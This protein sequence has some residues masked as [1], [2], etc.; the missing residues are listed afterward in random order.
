MTDVRLRA[1]LPLRS[2]EV[3]ATASTTERSAHLAMPNAPLSLHARLGTPSGEA[4]APD[5]SI[6]AVRSVPFD[7]I[8][9]PALDG[10]DP[11]HAPFFE[12][13]RLDLEAADDLLELSAHLRG[14]SLGGDF[15]YLRPEATLDARLDKIASHADEL[16]RQ[17]TGLE[18]RGFRALQ[19][20]T[21]V[22]QAR[23]EIG[24]IEDAMSRVGA[25]TFRTA[26]ETLETTLARGRSILAAATKVKRSISGTHADVV[27]SAERELSATVGEGRALATLSAIRAELTGADY[28]LAEEALFDLQAKADVTRRGLAL[29]ALLTD[30]E[31]LAED[32][33]RSAEAESLIPALKAEIQRG[34]D[35]VQYVLA[36]DRNDA[37]RPPPPERTA[38]HETLIDGV[39]S[40]VEEPAIETR[41]RASVAELGRL[42]LRLLDG[43][44]T[45]SVRSELGREILA[46]ATG[47][48]K[49][50]V[51]QAAGRSTDAAG[52]R[53]TELLDLLTAK[54]RLPSD[55]PEPRRSANA[56]SEICD[57]YASAVA[58]NRPLDGDLA[59][60]LQ[61]ADT[62]YQELMAK[63]L[64]NLGRLLAQPATE[65]ESGTTPTGELS[66][67]DVSIR[68]LQKTGA[69]PDLLSEL[70]D[71]CGALQLAT[72]E[73]R[74]T[75]TAAHL[76]AFE[77]SD[78]PSRESRRVL[79]FAAIVP[80]LDHQITGDKHRD[81]LIA[82]RDRLVELGQ[83]A[84][85]ALRAAT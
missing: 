21:L 3:G 63:L 61:S 81:A 49:R 14:P 20:K 68:L 85:A 56:A 29:K 16:G 40:G 76:S 1:S 70:Q 34:M 65:V 43:V 60:A 72:L 42:A 79:E 80:E 6:V 4:A 11:V 15:Q 39:R 78:A 22:T 2:T 50:Q 82:A 83:R 32:G 7:R 31:R 9:V 84:Q 53:A 41:P 13:A 24:R 52:A 33:P 75:H 54:S 26:P 58:L 35:I 10:L 55:T 45:A 77:A 30:A 23:L 64:D 18:R 51:D 57:A 69:A 73:A 38:S 46:M 62:R 48:L 27:K 25:G 74:A 59:T 17:H 28:P 5:Q 66:T 19:V 67:L 71:R 8:E 47:S 37:D 36:N 44:E 12:R